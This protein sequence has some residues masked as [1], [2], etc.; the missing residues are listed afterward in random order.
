L[1]V[2]PRIGAVFEPTRPLQ[3]LPD[4]AR[5]IEL[6]GFDELWVVEDCFAYGGLTA[7]ATAL[8][9]TGHLSVGVGLLPASVRNVAITAMELGAL[10]ELHPRRIQA[11]FGHGVE[12]WMRQIG[13]RPPDRLAALGEVVTAARALLNGQTVTVD[14]EH[15]VLDHVALEHAPREPP[16]I[17]IGTAGPRGIALA[18]DLADG[19]LLPQGTGPAAVTWASESLRRNSRVTVYTWLRVEDDPDEARGLLQPVVHAW[20][21]AGLYP[22]LVAR[23]GLT[24]AGGIELCELE[25]VAIVGTPSQCAKQVMRL[26]CAGASSVVLSPIGEDPEVQLERFSADVLPL[27]LAD[28]MLS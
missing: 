4:G 24:P 21:D 3:Q 1:S 14:G 25:R 20:R 19:L 16:T 15:V 13:A 12:T 27:V 2:R 22:N 23:S 18:G 11:A 5:Q 6:L 17:L 28:C 9:S 7:A 8:A 26:H 10:A